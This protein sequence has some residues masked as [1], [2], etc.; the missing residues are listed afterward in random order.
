VLFKNEQEYVTKVA[1]NVQEA[2][3]LIEEGW[4]YCIG[5]CNDGGKIFAKPEDLLAF[6]Q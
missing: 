6:E 5:E 3:A 4:K 2:C 1:H